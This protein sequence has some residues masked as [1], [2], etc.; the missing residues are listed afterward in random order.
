M[1]P[2]VAYSLKNYLFGARDHYGPYI[3]FHGA[4]PDLNDHG[5]AI[6][7]GKRLSR[8][9]GRGHPS[10]NYNQWIDWG[11]AWLFVFSHLFIFVKV[12]T[13]VVMQYNDW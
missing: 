7:V 13:F 10:L 3:C 9:P 6:Y 2:N 12:S 8:E 5:H 1:S 4:L 11:A